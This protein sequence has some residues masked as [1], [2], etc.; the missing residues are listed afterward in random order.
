MRFLEILAK[1]RGSGSNMK[2]K[3]NNDLHSF[4]MT[5]LASVPYEAVVQYLEPVI[6]KYSRFKMGDRKFHAFFNF[7]IQEKQSFGYKQ[8]REIIQMHEAGDQKG[9][10]KKYGKEIATRLISQDNPFL[11]S[12]MW[13]TMTGWRASMS[14]TGWDDWRKE[15]M[16]TANR[17]TGVGDRYIL[18]AGSEHGGGEH[19]GHFDF[20]EDEKDLHAH[21][22]TRNKRGYAYEKVK[23]Y[24]L[25]E[26]GGMRDFVQ[27]K[28]IDLKNEMKSSGDVR[29]SEI[30]KNPVEFE[31]YWRQIGIKRHESEIKEKSKEERRKN[32]HG[33][34]I[35][36]IMQ[37][38]RAY[39]A[40]VWAQAVMR[41]PLI[42][43]REWGKENTLESKEF[44][45]L[46]QG[47]LRRKILREI[48]HFDLPEMGPTQEPTKQQEEQLNRI[49]VLEGQLAS[50]SEK[51]RRENRDLQDEDFEDIVDPDQRVLALRYW[52]KVQKAV[53]GAEGNHAGQAWY[54][55]LGIQSADLPDD[56]E[57]RT[58]ILN[59][60]N[61]FLKPDGK[62]DLSDER[63]EGL[64]SHKIDFNKISQ[65]INIHADGKDYADIFHGGH[66]PPGVNHDAMLT[67]RMI[68]KDWRYFFSTEDMGWEYLNMVALGERNPVRRAGD[69]ASHVQFSQGL[70]KLIA[71]AGGAIGPRLNEEEFHKALTEMFTAIEG[72]DRDVAYD[73]VQR[74]F[75]NSML[76]Y[77]KMT[78]SY[79]KIPLIG[80]GA[81]KIK[82]FLRPM[83]V[84]QILSEPYGQMHADAFG[85]QD[86]L[87][88]IHM[89]EAA[90][91]ILPS[92][93]NPLTGERDHWTEW[94]AH[95]LESR[96]GAGKESLTYDVENYVLFLMFM[97]LLW[98]SLKQSNADNAE[99]GGGG[100]PPGH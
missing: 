23:E 98:Q 58:Y 35:E 74:I 31:K 43:A 90:G 99:G 12:S 61:G 64:R 52:H 92:D 19:G 63:L 68:D 95:T 5:G 15:R 48:L 4:N 36:L 16:S 55:A 26:F 79:Y 37:T 51:S 96:L 1:S 71:P 94:N 82:G 89:G 25:Y 54:D 9:L 14:T 62:V 41:S 20:D 67:G 46:G 100:G 91:Y 87:K 7:M 47:A 33:N 18:Q 88:Q 86:I 34:E 11:F 28:K 84:M 53:L 29:L 40:R 66:L 27:N 75:Y 6:Y 2:I 80:W 45:Y 39:K 59:P 93:I 97:L 21:G 32:F 73:T 76:M 72:D 70:D 24:F 57:L 50:I 83:S 69:L 10:E 60:E 8:I 38:E 42:V 81:A 65:N 17:L 30:A 44:E 56:N 49:T 22:S 13:G 77:R 78:P 85:A 3:N